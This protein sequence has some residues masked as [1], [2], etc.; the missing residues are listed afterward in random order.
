MKTIIIIGLMAVLLQSCSTCEDCTTTY[1]DVNGTAV[2]HSTR[3][4][5]GTPREIRQQ[6]GEVRYE[7]GGFTTITRTEC[8]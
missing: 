8:R 7:N 6:E 5:C 2:S 3:E 4:F 1:Y